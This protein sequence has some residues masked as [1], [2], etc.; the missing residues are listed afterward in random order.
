MSILGEDRRKIETADLAQMKYLERV[1]KEVLRLY[2]SVPAFL[3]ALHSD[4]VL[5]PI[6]GKKGKTG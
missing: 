6:N 2:P 3:R 5:P 4:L 1:I